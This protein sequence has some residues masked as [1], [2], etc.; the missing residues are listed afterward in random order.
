MRFGHLVILTVSLVTKAAAKCN[1]DDCEIGVKVG[2]AATSPCATVGSVLCGV[3][4]GISCADGLGC[5]LAAGA[6]EVCTAFDYQ[7]PNV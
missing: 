3:I 5:G 6:K 2:V 7:Q 4:F 1:R